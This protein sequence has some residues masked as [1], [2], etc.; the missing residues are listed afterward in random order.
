MVKFKIEYGFEAENYLSIDA[1]ELEKAIYAHMTGARA[2][3]REGSIDFSRKGIV[4]KP[5]YHVAMGWTQGY[6]LGVDDYAELSDRG[7]DREH[8]IFQAKT[9]ERV[10]YLVSNGKQELIGKNIEIPELESPVK[11]RGGEMKQIGEFL[12]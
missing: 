11:K 4:I 3:F 10:E 8:K 2:S 6:K 12:K 7:V 1:D 9:K 5:D